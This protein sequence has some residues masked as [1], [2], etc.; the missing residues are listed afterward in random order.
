MPVVSLSYERLSRMVG[1]PVEEVRKS[2]P[3]L[4]LDIEY[5]DGDTVRIEYSPN[6]L[7]YSTEYG[8]AL[9]LRGMLDIETGIY[10]VRIAAAKWR[11]E[12][13]ESVLPVRPA[14]TGMVARE[15]RLDTND[16]KQIIAMQ[17]DLHE[18]LGR[19]RR[20]L[21][22]GLH[23]LDKMVFPLRYTTVTRDFE[24]QPLGQTEPMAVHRILSETDQGIHYGRLLLGERIPVILDGAG[25]VASMPPVINSSHTTVTEDTRNLFIDITGAAIRDIENALAVVCVTLQAAGFALERVNVSGA[26]NHTP[27]MATREMTISHAAPN[28]MIGLEMTSEETAGCLR[29]SR[30]DARV[31]GSIIHCTIPAYRFDMF[32]PMDIVEEVALGYGVDNMEPSVPGVQ[33][34]GQPSEVSARLRC[35]DRTM[36]GLGFTEAVNS[37]LI[38][39]DVT[40]RAGGSAS[41]GARRITVANSKSQSH[42]TLRHSLLPGLLENLSGNIHEPY[43]HRLYETGTTFKRT[44][45]DFVSEPIHLGCVTAHQGASYS[46]AKSVLKSVLGAGLAEEMRTPP[47]DG[48]SF[49]QGRTAAVEVSGAQIGTIGEISGEVCRAF[50]IRE[51]ISVAAFEM[52]VSGLI[53]DR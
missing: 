43:P 53:F 23:D 12:A 24:F 51:G 37:S 38:G 15:H 32:G 25:R 39:S 18:G 5:E 9:G 6:R 41:Q 1:A 31:D 2:L 28:R 21:A 4:G 49:R 35:I 42:T 7:D 33:T 46:E 19:K 50:R 13:D 10:P 47:A 17:E 29:R 40:S 22:I 14:I 20:K 11:L 3:F 36:T 48:A 8:L 45:E 16:I 52:D 34:V 26:G 44:S 27:E 30:L